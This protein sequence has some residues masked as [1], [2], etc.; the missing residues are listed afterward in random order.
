MG[1][2]IC[3]RCK[4]EFLPKISSDRYC[5]LKKCKFK[6]KELLPK[7]APMLLSDEE[8]ENKRRD[9]HYKIKYGISLE[10]Y[11][12][13]LELRNSKCEICNKEKKLYVDH[14]HKTGKIRGLLC[15]SCNTA[16]GLLEDDIERLTNSIN[17]LQK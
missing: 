3:E 16:I 11:N 10:E 1:V 8:K 4:R 5:G 7:S 15:S 12:I 6:K 9:R 13:M 17:Y 2:K 14:C